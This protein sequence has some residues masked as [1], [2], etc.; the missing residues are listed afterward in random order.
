VKSPPQ[1]IQRRR[2]RGWRLPPH[3]V[4][5][6]RPGKWGNPFRVGGWFRWETRGAAGL[7][8]SE[9]PRPGM[10]GYTL[11]ADKS[12]AV[13]WFA[14]WREIAPLDLTE[15][16]GKNLACWCRPGDP[17]HADILL[18]LASSSRNSVAK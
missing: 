10:T 5:V 3:T 18:R 7:P 9:A 13:A 4:C 12:T 15:L 16:Q 11:I 17:C 6:T 8:W 2:S 14:K 1:R